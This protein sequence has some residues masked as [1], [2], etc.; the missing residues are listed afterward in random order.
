[1]AAGCRRASRPRA[2]GALRA[3]HPR[4]RRP[5]YKRAQ[6]HCR[7]GDGGGFASSAGAPGRRSADMDDARLQGRVRRRR[8]PHEAVPESPFRRAGSQAGRRCAALSAA[9]GRGSLRPRA[10]IEAGRPDTWPQCSA[11]TR[12]RGGR[13]DALGP[14]AG[15]VSCHG[16]ASGERKL[17]V[18]ETKRGRSRIQKYPARDCGGPKGISCGP[19]LQ[20]RYSAEQKVSLGRTGRPPGPG[21]QETPT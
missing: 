15:H 21:R 3:L 18:G 11:R 6:A 9:R 1:M 19:G 10:G 7:A 4:G 8:S 17:R 13:P 5:G 2:P 16:G 12:D 14:G 20:S